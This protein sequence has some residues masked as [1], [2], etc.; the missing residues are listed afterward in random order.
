MIWSY[1]L[2]FLAQIGKAVILRFS[3]F[4]DI[5]KVLIPLYL[6]QTL[7]DTHIGPPI[8]FFCLYL[9]VSVVT[10]LSATS[11]IIYRIKSLSGAGKYFY[12]IEA[13]IQSG[14]IYS[15]SNVTTAS[16]LAA[17]EINPSKPA[18]IQVTTYEGGFLTPLAVSLTLSIAMQCLTTSI[19]TQLQG[20]ITTWMSTQL[21]AQQE[22]EKRKATTA[23]SVLRFQ[24]PIP[25]S[26]ETQQLSASSPVE[27]QS[28]CAPGPSY[29]ILL[30]VT[31]N[32][33]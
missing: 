12:I 33:K 4:S 27:Q 18:L 14:A 11:L 1:A 29:D 23:L 7:I 24:P 32:T 15:L 25:P 5:S 2:I 31:P 21:I 8:S 3:E 9:F 16:L 30:V 22:K 26:M 19:E 10:T 6:I 17:R 28:D 13:L 20:I